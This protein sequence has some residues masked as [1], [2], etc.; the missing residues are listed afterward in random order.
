MK[1]KKP[2]RVVELPSASAAREI[3]AAEIREARKSATRI[4]PRELDDAAK[5]IW[6]SI[7]PRLVLLGRLTPET[8]DALGEYCVAL[9]EV[10]ALRDAIKAEGRVVESEGRYGEQMRNS[11]LV[12]QYDKAWARW[13]N[14]AAA[15]GATPADVRAMPAPPERSSSDPWDDL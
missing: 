9:A 12:Q 15:F 1:G 4:R 10:R 3:S 11:P 2:G 5:K 6:S 13:R 7:A 8:A 14:L